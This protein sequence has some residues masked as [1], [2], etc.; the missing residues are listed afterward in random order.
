MIKDICVN[1]MIKMQFWSTI[2]PSLS[3]HPL[4]LPLILFLSFSLR[5]SLT[6][7]SSLSS[8]LTAAA[9]STSEGGNDGGRWQTGSA[10]AQRRRAQG[11]GRKIRRVC[12]VDR[13]S[14]YGQRAHAHQCTHMFWLFV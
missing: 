13:P 6:L 3:L 8:L 4:L 12:A 7:S 11:F 14:G 9:G 1:V 10:K 5:S 2:L